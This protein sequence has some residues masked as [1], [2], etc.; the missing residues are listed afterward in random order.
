MRPANHDWII[1]ALMI[2][3]RAATRVRHEDLD[4]K[5]FL[6]A[7]QLFVKNRIG[8]SAGPARDKAQAQYLSGQSGV[9]LHSIADCDDH[10]LLRWLA[11][12]DDLRLILSKLLGLLP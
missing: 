5:R 8:L 1:A 9:T 2:R 7:R 10:E 11:L 3:R 12:H 4:L 6:S